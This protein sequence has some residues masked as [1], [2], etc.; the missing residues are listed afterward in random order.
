MKLYK[1]LR[2]GAIIFA[3]IGGIMLGKA[4]FIAGILVV[5]LGLGL[6]IASIKLELKK[7]Y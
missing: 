6:T 3:I 1:I 2:H 4:I 7:R 5:A